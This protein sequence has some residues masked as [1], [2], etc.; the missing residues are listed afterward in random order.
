[1][2]TIMESIIMTTAS[3]KTYAAVIDSEGDEKN[4]KVLYF[5]N[6]PRCAGTLPKTID[7]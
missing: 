5:T 2:Y 4:W 7:D 1:M 3:R 6:D